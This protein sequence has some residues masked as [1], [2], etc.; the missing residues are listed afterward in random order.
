MFNPEA[1]H[2]AFYIFTELLIHNCESQSV[3]FW[4]LNFKVIQTYIDFILNELRKVSDP[5]IV[6]EAG[7]NILLNLIKIYKKYF[8]VLDKLGDSLHHQL[9]L[10]V[11]FVISIIH[12]KNMDLYVLTLKQIKEVLAIKSYDLLRLGKFKDMLGV[13]AEAYQVTEDLKV[14]KCLISYIPPDIFDILVNCL[15]NIN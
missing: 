15:P 1:R 2:S 9:E 11:S 5:K 7:K 13:L 10:F 14:M 12:L 4:G 3:E 6:E 8:I